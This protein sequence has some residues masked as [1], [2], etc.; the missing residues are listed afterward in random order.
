MQDSLAW[1]QWNA[2]EWNRQLLLFCF[3]KDSQAEA[4]Q[5][6]RSSEDDLPVLT[7]DD[8]ATGTEQAEALLRAIKIHARVQPRSF[9]PASL[10]ADQVMLRVNPL[11][12]RPTSLSPDIRLWCSAAWS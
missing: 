7:G 1:K 8:A 3:V 12:R 10:M 9:T 6:I 2:E 11:G 4:W 5:G